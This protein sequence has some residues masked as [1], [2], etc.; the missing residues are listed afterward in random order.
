V[1]RFL[2]AFFCIAAISGAVFY[3]VSVP[4]ER[5]DIKAV[6]G[7]FDLRGADLG[8]D[9]FALG[10]EWEFYWDRLYEPANFAG[11]IPGD[12][13]TFIETP[14]AWNGAGY[15]RT[16]QATWRLMLLL[17]EEAGAA[18]YV[19]EILGASAVWVN[20]EKVFTA[21]RLGTGAEDSVPYS[22]NEI[23]PIHG[24]GGIAEIVVQVSNYHRMNGGIRHAFRIG[25][26]HG[27]TRWAFSRWLVI[28]GLAGAFFLMG[29]YH[30]MLYLSGRSLRG[31]RIYAVFAVCCVLAGIRF[32]IEQ[33]SVAQFF[34]RGALNTWFNPVYWILFT[35][36]TGFIA[37][38]TA[39]A[40]ELELSRAMKISLAFLLAAPLVM[41]ALP[42]PL[43]RFGL[44]L[45][46]ATYP[47]L[48]AMSVRGF[49]MERVRERPYLGLFLV[50]LLCYVCWGPVANSPARAF[51]FAASVLFNTFI[52]LSQCVVLSLDYAEAR[53]RA[54][55]LAARADLYHRLSHDLLTPLTV[56]STNIQVANIEPE[57]DH[58]RLV[59]SQAEIM[60]MAEM[61]NRAL[62]EGRNAED[63]DE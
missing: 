58:E 1:R 22:K 40:F 48:A 44:F 57:T 18:L 38:F 39:M 11:S 25:S 19:P 60:K 42:A 8:R 52:M 3:V 16:G 23:L 47:V 28:S 13:K 37:V 5:S 56:V 6:G 26:E 10:G 41:M 30:L 20:G 29:F 53:R 7:V 14:M 55:E 50:A 51:F 59:K 31:E 24:N 33:D 43:N 34:S 49:D 15:P 63:R 61:I 45:N 27:L 32:L 9:V 12:G 4:H 17:P 2:L 46:I 54:R 35:L 62:A 21:G 36:H